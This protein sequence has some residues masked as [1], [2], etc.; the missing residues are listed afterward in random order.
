MLTRVRGT[1]DFIDMTLQKYVL[2]LAFEHFNQHNFNE[3]QTPILE[4]TAVFTHALGETTDVV[5]KEMYVFESRQSDGTEGEEK[6]ICLRPEATAAIIRACHE[7]RIDRFPWKVFLHGPIFRRER[8]QKG[9][10]R[11]FH[12]ISLEV[13]GSAAF[14]HDII[15]IKMLDSLFSQKLKL[16]N[17][18]LK[19]NFLGCLDDRKQHKA[20]L[21]DF[22]NSHTDKI[23]ATCVTRKDANT[24]RVFDCKNLHCQQLYKTAPKL[25]DHLCSPCSQEW[26]A[27]KDTLHV[28]AVSYVIDDYLVRGLDYYYN[29]VF[30][31]VSNEL[32]SQSAFAGGGRY[33][34]GRHVGAAKDYDAV[35]VGIGVERLMMLVELVQNDL[36]IPPKPPLTVIM[37]MGPEQVSLALLLATEVQRAGITVD[38]IVERAS[39][40]NMM[41]RA[42]KMGASFVVVIGEQEQ[43]N[44]MVA[45]KDMVTG[46]MISIKQTDLVE[47]LLA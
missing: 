31:F 1:Q 23:C 14:E 4:H 39:M 27:I 8:P 21:V 7:N 6:S 45:V 16:K 29:I 10:F 15:L 11:E 42:N 40:T 17:Y 43:Q 19:L 44:G 46:S 47:H 25:T 37:P 34:L 41:K 18:V 36:V 38:V 35:G 22:L 13:I 30:E 9:R 28:L 20:V 26:L 2:A 12:Q 24:L 33:R 3:I 32:G 5:S